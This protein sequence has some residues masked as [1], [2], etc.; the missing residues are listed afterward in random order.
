MWANTAVKMDVLAALRYTDT[1]LE[2]WLSGQL[3]DPYLEE[4]PGDHIS[5]MA[6]A[7]YKNMGRASSVLNLS[8]IAL[9]AWMTV[10]T[11]EQGRAYQALI[12][13]HRQVISSLNEG[14]TDEY[15]LLQF[16]RD[17][18]SGRDLTAFYDFTAG[19]AGLTMSRTRR[20][21]WVPRFTT[22]KLEVLIMGHNDKL[23]PI[24]ESEGFQNIAAAIRRS[25]II[26]QGFK[27][28]GNKGPYNVRYNL[29]AKLLR[30][31]AYPDQF[32]Q[33]L[34]DF[35]H[36]YNRE[37]LQIYERYDGDPPVRR[38]QVTTDDIQ[39]VV[40]LID[41]HGSETVA[42]LL[43]AFGY[44]REPRERQESEAADQDE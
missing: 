21:Q 13:E 16:Y 2:Q 18:L 44:A 30:Q 9:P 28:R 32:I 31:A 25:T 33:T 39:Q 42:N 40:A 6:V 38:A 29:G 14:Q 12:E 35:L 43:V 27:A 1:F 22:T 5:G 26:P 17:F 3:V 7:F 20:G 15:R 8:R 23:S 4:Q 37:T 10:E 19:Y 36:D 41:E 24:L 11:E 34:S